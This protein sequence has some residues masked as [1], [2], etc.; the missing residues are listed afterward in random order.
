MLNR[1]EKIDNLIVLTLLILYSDDSVI[2][3]RYGVNNDYFEEK[4]KACLGDKI[5]FNYEYIKYCFETRRLINEL[6]D[7]W[8]K[9]IESLTCLYRQ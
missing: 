7:S 5:L 2:A 6:N 9:K 1:K 3:Y 8:V 4:F